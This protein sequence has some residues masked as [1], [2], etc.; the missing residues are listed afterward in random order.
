MM[1]VMKRILLTEIFVS[2]VLT[3]PAFGQNDTIKKPEEVADTLFRDFGLFASDDILK[4]TLRFDITRFRWKKPKDEY[5]KALLT[6]HI[7]D[8]DSINK[9]V[10]LKSRGTMRNEYC[11]FPPIKLNFMK[12]D[13]LQKVPGKITNLKMVTHCQSGNEEYLLKEYLIY[14]LYNELTD[15]SFRVRLVRVEYI[16]THKKSKPIEAY[17]FLIE[18]EEMLAERTHSKQQK[19]TYISQKAIMPEIMD[20][21]AIFNYMIGNTDWSVAM[22]HNIKVLK[23]PAADSSGQ[24]LIVP[25]DFDFSG[26]VNAHYAL[27]AEGLGLESVRDRRYLGICRSEDVFLNDIKEFRDKKDDF[28]R[29]INEFSRISDRTKKDIIR[30]LDSFYSGFDSHNSIVYELLNSCVS[31]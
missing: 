9:E 8:K 3:Y 20:R 29:V 30:Y 7:S 11:D 12:R 25:Y 1:T 10:R 26:L 19:I 17:A 13:S 18:P 15:F 6:Y 21:V 14:K 23:E 22:Q 31:F 5:M 28:Y 4:L 2:L 24:A 27:P 16:N